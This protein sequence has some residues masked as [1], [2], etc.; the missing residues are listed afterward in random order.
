M[1]VRGTTPRLLDA[2]SPPRT[3]PDGAKRPLA[4]GLQRQFEQRPVVV[5]LAIFAGLLTFN[6]GAGL[7]LKMLAPNLP[8]LVPDLIV[9][10][11]NVVAIVALLTVLGWWREVGY[12]RPAVW[13]NLT[14]LALPALLAIVAPLARGFNTAEVGSLALLTFGY[15]LTGFNEESWWRGL[16]LRIL[17]PGGAVRACVI[18][19]VLFGALHLGN[20][21]YRSNP[22]LVFG[23]VVGAACF[24]FAYA[25]L[26]LRTNTIWFLLPLH[27]LG[28]LFLHYTNLPVI[29]LDVA[30]DIVL[31]V[32]GI[33]VVRSLSTPADTTMANT[34]R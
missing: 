31:L 2:N 32:F 18:S 10:V 14:L 33:I 7:T 29:P 15:A 3:P 6:M 28:D 9:L 21:V 1:S 30:R 19:A 26:R 27:M 34:A 24:G 12:N 13:R 23:Q 11:L 17:Q 4:S 22:A 5:A 20:L 16:V 25:A 8:K